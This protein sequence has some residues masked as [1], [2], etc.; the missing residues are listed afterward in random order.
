MK[1][2]AKPAWS[3]HLAS[4]TLL[5]C[6]LRSTSDS[7]CSLKMLAFALICLLNSRFTSTAP[8]IPTSSKPQHLQVMSFLIYRM[9]IL[10]KLS[11]SQSIFPS[12]L[13]AGWSRWFTA[14]R[15]RP[16]L[17][18]LISLIWLASFPNAWWKILQSW[19]KTNLYL[20]TATLLHGRSKL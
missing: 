4:Q 20:L 3:S 14:K 10:F 13:V 2:V 6:L 5:T 16:P 17:K 19:L 18:S 12:N 15:A 11:P 8:K 9:W 7:T 1:L